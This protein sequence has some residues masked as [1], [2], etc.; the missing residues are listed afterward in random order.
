MKV[1]AEVVVVQLMS[2]EAVRH[3]DG[4]VEKNCHLHL[5]KRSE[6]TAGCKHRLGA[7]SLPLGSEAAGRSTVG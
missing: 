5:K 4:T 7:R 3:E 1:Y 2:G 6:G